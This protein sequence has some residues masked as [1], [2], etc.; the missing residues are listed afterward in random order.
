MTDETDPHPRRQALREAVHEG[1][2]LANGAERKRRTADALDDHDPTGARWR[3][4]EA[5]DMEARAEALLMLPQP[6]ERGVGGELQVLPE[7][8]HEI[9]GLACV[10]ND[11]PDAVRADA[12]YDRMGLLADA[13]C[14]ST[15]LEAAEGASDP[16]EKMMVHQMATLHSLGMRAAAAANSELHRMKIAQGIVARQAASV[17]AARQAGV[18]QRL[19]A[20]YQQGALARDRLRNGGRQTVVVQHVNVSGDAQAVIAGAVAARKTGGD[21]GG[22]NG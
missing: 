1:I 2:R 3:R 13:N 14:L 7:M 4:L 21:E 18:A 6:L 17:E 8:E 9:P 16:L 19:F 5:D 20:T 10:V 15:G 22:G 12:S 11:S